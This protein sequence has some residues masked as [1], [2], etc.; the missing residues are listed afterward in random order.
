MPVGKAWLSSHSWGCN[1]LQSLRCL[2]FSNSLLLRSRLSQ[3]RGLEGTLRHACLS[4]KLGHLPYSRASFS[5]NW[6]STWHLLAHCLLHGVLEGI[7]SSISGL[8]YFWRGVTQLFLTSLPQ[9]PLPSLLT[10]HPST[11]STSNPQSVPPLFLSG[12]DRPP[13]G[14]NK[15]HGISVCSKIKHLPMCPS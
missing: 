7:V 4:L 14:I 12:K 8:L 13:M 1:A 6:S 15:N 2:L 5:V 3:D 10:V 9:F 11:P